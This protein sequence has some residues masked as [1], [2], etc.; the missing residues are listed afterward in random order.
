MYQFYSSVIFTYV[1]ENVN[2][3]KFPLSRLLP[4]SEQE[5][6][7]LAAVLLKK[8]YTSEALAYVNNASR[9]LNYWSTGTEDLLPGESAGHH[10]F[11][12]HDLVWLGIV[13]ECRDFGLSK[14]VLYKLKEKLLSNVDQSFL[15]D[16]VVAN[17]TEFEDYL[18]SGGASTKEAK[19]FVELMLSN[20]ET[21]RQH[22]QTLLLSH[23]Y[24][25]VLEK[26][27]VY[28][29]VNKEGDY[30]I[31]YGEELKNGYYYEGFAAF[32]NA[33]HLSILLNDIVGFFLSKSFIQD[34]LKE[35][36]FTKDEWKIIQTIRHEKPDA[37]T[38]KFS[39]EGRVEHLSVTKK[40]KVQLEAR[41]SEIIAAGSY[42]TITIVTQNGKPVSVKKQRTIK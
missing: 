23:I 20:K 7:D 42:E 11:S 24:S 30:E 19:A 40:K 27:P 22:K 2:L 17:P 25:V 28:L 12:F 31:L 37:I 35:K 6:Q 9:T 3:K 4:V 41:L 14:A 34:N 10:R 15:L 16:K 21:F 32:F 36:L 26:H 1:Y 39:G 18:V 33:P 29:L 13:K 5:V 8:D 38:V